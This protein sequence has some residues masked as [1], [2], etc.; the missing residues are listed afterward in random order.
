[1]SSLPHPLLVQFIAITP[2]DEQELII[3][4]ELMTCVSRELSSCSVSQLSLGLSP[5]ASHS[6]FGF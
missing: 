3:V 1:M 2:D 6:R 5:I 4:T